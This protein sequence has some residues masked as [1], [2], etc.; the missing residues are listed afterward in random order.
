[1]SLHWVIVSP[2]TA[3]ITAVN[4]MNIFFYRSTIRSIQ[5]AGYLF[6]FSVIAVGLTVWTVVVPL[7]KP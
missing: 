5:S 4:I 3:F 2:Q 7:E 1:M 6:F